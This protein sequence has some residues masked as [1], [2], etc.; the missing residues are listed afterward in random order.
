MVPIQ[1]QG[2]AIS[3]LSMNCCFE[4]SLARRQNL[5]LTWED[6][7]NHGRI[8]LSVKWLSHR[9]VI[10]RHDMRRATGESFYRVIVSLL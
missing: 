9:S 4:V 3:R 8:E 7:W 10:V 1:L 6:A 2:L 5:K